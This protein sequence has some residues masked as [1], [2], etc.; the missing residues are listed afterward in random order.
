MSAEGMEPMVEIYVH[1]TEQLIEQLETIVIESEKTGAFDSGIPEIFRL[2]HTIK[3][4]SMMMHYDGIARVAHSA[5]DLFDYLRAERPAEIDAKAIADLMLEVLDYI[6]SEIENIQAGETETGSPED[7]LENLGAYLDSLRFLNGG[8]AGEVGGED[9][10]TLPLAVPDEGDRLYHVRLL[11]EEDC[12]MENVRAFSI[13]HG[14]G[15]FCK[16]VLHRPGEFESPESEEL[17]REEGLE[18]LAVCEQVLKQLEDFFS[19]TSFLRNL[20]IKEIDREAFMDLAEGLQGRGKPVLEA[21]QETAPEGDPSPETER[22][23]RT[24]KSAASRK[25]KY[26]SVNVEKLDQLMNL[27]GEIVVSE[28][29]VT[30]SPELRGLELDAFHKAA[31]QMRKIINDLQDVV[32]EIRMVPLSLTFQ[33]MNRI[34]RDI[35]SKTG[36]D[37]ALELVGQETEVDKNIIEH[38][39]DPLMHLI[40]NAID[41][42]IELPE[43]RRAAGKPARGKVVLEAKHAGGDV[44]ITVKDDGGGLDREK[45]LAKALDR[46]LL[47]P[48]DHYS[49][50][51]VLGVIFKPG[52]STK[53]EITG[54]SGRGVGMDVAVRDI[55]KIGG[56]I[57]VESEP[58]KGTE[59]I[60]RIPLTLAIVDG[61]ITR[62]GRSRFTLP[63]TS[64]KESFKA[65]PE[66]L[67][68]DTRGSEMV[69]VRGDCYPVVRLH[70]RFDLETGITTIQ[71]GILVMIEHDGKT[72]CL[73]AD[74]LVGEHQVVVKSFSKFLRR[75]EGLSGCAL[76]GDGGIS[77]ILDPAGLV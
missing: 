33:K 19:R 13:V 27:V 20:E 23:A 39:S 25:Q 29:M 74:E 69:L 37:V 62:V 46:G 28:A 14:L 10:G 35:C 57:R 58:G 70:E 40:R 3:G 65:R 18:L 59:F 75:I 61:M 30:G 49:D 6:K 16:Q 73:L 17:I 52:F 66:D 47:E 50:K 76:L 2:M 32:M 5:E 55:E 77:M 24:D 34:V 43:A 8:P 67:V 26:I 44:W 54:F 21:E 68:R 71:D 56:V 36:K 31:G 12:Q 15:E 42:G 60:I 7:L 51:E 4:N 11:F 22:K 45:I 72:S 48:R 9:A 38:I 63:I 1:E 64:I 53:E 41:H